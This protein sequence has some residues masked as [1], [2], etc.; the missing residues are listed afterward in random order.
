MFYLNKKQNSLE[1]WNEKLY[2]EK[3]GVSASVSMTTLLS[4]YGL[5][6]TEENRDK[7]IK[8]ALNEFASRF[9]REVPY[10]KW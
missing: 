6:D 7:I 4:Y 5:K 8:N 3:L 9:K 1:R 10:L 2:I